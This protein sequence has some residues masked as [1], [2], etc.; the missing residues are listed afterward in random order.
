MNTTN[1]NQSTSRQHPISTNN[2][3]PLVKQRRTSNC[4]NPRKEGKENIYNDAPQQHISQIK[5][6]DTIDDTFESLTMGLS[7]VTPNESERESLTDELL[8]EEEV[9]IER[10][11]KRSSPTNNERDCD[12]VS[13][14]E[15]HRRKRANNRGSLLT[16][17]KKARNSQSG[18][19]GK[20]Y[21]DSSYKEHNNGLLDI[22]F[23]IERLCEKFPGA[24]V[25]GLQSEDGR[26]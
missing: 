12:I 11:R 6:F 15:V 22:G 8:N 7:V 25:N 1:S 13:L 3:N 19:S 21:M 20:L 14:R 23:L 9:I 2:I 17:F 10:C 24:E 4:T 18:E 26:G 16:S 5:M